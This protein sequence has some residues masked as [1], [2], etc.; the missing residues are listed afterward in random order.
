MAPDALPPRGLVAYWIAQT[1]VV[2]S[3]WAT[4][5]RAIVVVALIVVA[6]SVGAGWAAKLTGGFDRADGNGACG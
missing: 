4:A 1:W 3:G 6:V 2:Q 5:Y